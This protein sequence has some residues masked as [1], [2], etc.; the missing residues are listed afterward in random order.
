MAESNKYIDAITLVD[1]VDGTGGLASNYQLP[2][3]NAINAPVTISGKT[4]GLS[5]S[6]IYDGSINLTGKDLTISTGVG[7]ETLNYSG[8]TASSKDVAVSNKYID[9]V[10]L[11][12]ALMDREVW[13]VIINCQVWM[14]LMLRSAFQ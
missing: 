1:A 10:T 13:L 6:R 7:S 8:A 12:D 4:V 9:A 5:A 2:S 11:V 14:R 3:L